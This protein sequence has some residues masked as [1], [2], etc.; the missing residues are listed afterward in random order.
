VRPRHF[1]IPNAETTLRRLIRP[2]G[3]S[4]E[5]LPVAQAF[6]L[7]IE[8]FTDWHPKGLSPN[9]DG[10]GLLFQWGTYD[11]GRNGNPRFEL[12]LTRQF[13]VPEENEDDEDAGDAV[14]FFQLAWTYHYE[15]TDITRELGEGDQWFIVPTAQTTLADLIISSP[16]VARA[17]T[18]TPVEVTLQFY[19]V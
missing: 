17:R 5:S 15:P 8:F 7:M 10:D 19:P 18:L 6:T 11:S 16:V 2:K 3:A 14:N 9:H 12:Y 1:A 4:L 13:I